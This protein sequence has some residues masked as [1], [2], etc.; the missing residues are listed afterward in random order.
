[1]TN[2]SHMQLS[3][4]QQ[5]KQAPSQLQDIN[6]TNKLNDIPSVIS[7]TYPILLTH[8]FTIRSQTTHNQS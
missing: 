1:M 2:N 7:I 8:T 3:V 6:H 5:G 4:M